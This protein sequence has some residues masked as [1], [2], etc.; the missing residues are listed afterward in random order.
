[1]ISLRCK[2]IEKMC[3]I[4]IQKNQKPKTKTTVLRYLHELAIYIVSY[5]LFV[6][7]YVHLGIHPAEKTEVIAK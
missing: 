7:G 5:T 6:V 1:M 4:Y 2:F 3:V